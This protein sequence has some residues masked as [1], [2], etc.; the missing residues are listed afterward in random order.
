[1]HADS[2]N[3][4]YCSSEFIWQADCF[5][6]GDDDDPHWI[7]A[8]VC[9]FYGVFLS[10]NEFE[11]QPPS[12]SMWEILLETIQ[13]EEAKR[14]LPQPKKLMARPNE[15]WE[16]LES[17]LQ[18]IGITLVLS[19]RVDTIDGF[20]EWINEVYVEWDKK[21]PK[22]EVHGQDEH[23]NVVIL[24]TGLSVVDAELAVESLKAVDSNRRYWPHRGRL[25]LDV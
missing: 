12:T 13:R 6:V 21:H 18:E 11:K 16:A 15:G 19:E 14:E 3:A 23:G 24:K 9:A 5:N 2:S 7:M 25:T 8:I 20:G 1:M 17:Q 10:Q 4:E 22:W